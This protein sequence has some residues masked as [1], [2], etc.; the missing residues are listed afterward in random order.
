MIGLRRG[1]GNPLWFRMEYIAF[2]PKSLLV[3]CCADRL[4]EKIIRCFKVAGFADS[5]DFFKKTFNVLHVF[6]D[7]GTENKIERFVLEG[8]V[9]GIRFD[10][11]ATIPDERASPFRI[12]IKELLAQNIRAE[13]RITAGTNF[14]D[15][16]LMRQSCAQENAQVSYLVVGKDKRCSEKVE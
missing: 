11:W 1:S 7:V 9:A 8:H 3:R 10:Q 12:V 5:L 16:G 13:P 4:F 2:G 15:L 14:Q 6:H